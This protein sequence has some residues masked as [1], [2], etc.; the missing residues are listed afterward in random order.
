MN[1]DKTMTLSRSVVYFNEVAEEYASW[2][3]VR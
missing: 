3:H 2:Y 1:K